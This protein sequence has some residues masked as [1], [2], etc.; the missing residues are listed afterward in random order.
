MIFQNHLQISKIKKNESRSIKV[1]AE[2]HES[3]LGCS[4]KLSIPLCFDYTPPSNRR[5]PF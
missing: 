4:L 3:T 2:Q 1:G 5:P